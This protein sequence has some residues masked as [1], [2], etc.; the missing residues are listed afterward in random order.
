MNN[1]SRSFDNKRFVLS[2]K[3]LAVSTPAIMGILNVTPDSFSDGGR[4]QQEKEALEHIERMATEGAH[5]IDIGGESTRPGAVPVSEEEEASRVVP[6]IRDA[7]RHFPEV[8]LSVDTTK[9]SVAKKALDAG[10]D[11]V[12]DISGLRFEP[13]LA[14]LCAE[15]QAI[16]VIMHSIGNPQTMQNQPFYSDL[17]KEIVTF[18]HEKVDQAAGCGVKQIILD[19]G[20]GFG[21]T[22]EHNLKIIGDL[23]AF[24]EF[25]YPVLAGASRKSFIGH[26]LAGQNGPR[27]V[28]N[29]L[30]GTLAAHYHALM[31][32]ASILRVHDVR[33]ASDMVKMY[34]AISSFEEPGR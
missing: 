31:N 9:Y 19:P 26:V 11:I 2:G 20:I 30:Q 13:R 17:I 34:S 18:F 7:A 16:L 23:R 1:I 5:I 29:R 8:L 4:F 15:Y 32:G 3:A 21:K 33:E 24:T 22:V 28:G 27:E 14:E 6:V 25:G 10:A 12:N